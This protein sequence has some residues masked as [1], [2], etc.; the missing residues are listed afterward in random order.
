[1]MGSSIV[2]GCSSSALLVRDP[3]ISP[4]SAS[5][6]IDAVFQTEAFLLAGIALYVL[7][8]FVGKSKNVKRAST[9]FV[10]YIVVVHL[11]N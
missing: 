8:F 11:K 1:M 10:S 4:D 9:W 2:G 5:L 3:I 7:T 6:T